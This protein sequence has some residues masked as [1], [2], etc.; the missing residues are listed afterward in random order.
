M[1]RI[2]TIVAVALALSGGTAVA[3]SYAPWMPAGPNDAPGG[4]SGPARP[5]SIGSPSPNAADTVGGGTNS[6]TILSH[7]IKAQ[8][9]AGVPVQYGASQAMATRP[10]DNPR[11]VAITDEYGNLYN[12][13][14]ER[15]GH[16][17]GM[18]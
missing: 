1:S 15:I 14:G 11:R 8:S 2:P 5:S 4:A 12:S 13:R 7:D 9:A 17:P 18:R 16:A 10:T 3:Q 6:T